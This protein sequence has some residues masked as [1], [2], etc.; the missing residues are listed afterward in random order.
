MLGNIFPDRACAW[1]LLFFVLPRTI[2]MTRRRR[3]KRRI[4]MMTTT[5]RE[6]RDSMEAVA[7][8]GGK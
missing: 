3:R 4:A 1:R 2:R 6:G 8:L 7:R 5:K